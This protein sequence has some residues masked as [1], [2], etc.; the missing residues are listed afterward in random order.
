M[1]R[2]A[3]T[4]VVALV[5]VGC[6]TL[7]PEP[8][9]LLTP[10]PADGMIGSSVLITFG[11]D[12]CVSNPY[13]GELVVDATYGTAFIATGGGDATPLPVVWRSGFTG[14]RSGSEVQVVDPQ[15][16]VVA[17]TGHVYV[18]NGGYV[19]DGNENM[20]ADWAWSGIPVPRAFFSCGRV[21]PQ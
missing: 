12:G 16:N 5:L 13:A 18:F 11:P 9:H 8:V 10:P 19:N 20:D 14:R 7:L 21:T 2:V 1:K 3:A 15:G 6:G 17:V 4:L